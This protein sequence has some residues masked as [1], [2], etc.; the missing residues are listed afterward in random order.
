MPGCIWSRGTAPGPYCAGIA[1]WG[2][3]HVLIHTDITSVVNTG[4]LVDRDLFHPGDSFTVPG[5]P[6]R[7][8]L[9]PIAGP[10]LRAGDMVDYFR[11]VAPARGYAIHEAI[12][13]DNGPARAW[14]ASSAVHRRPGT[15]ATARSSW[16]RPS[17]SRRSD[18]FR[19]HLAAW[20]GA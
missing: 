15:D 5:E 14:P 8:L 10:W 18:S 11:E 2:E 19:C 7:T 9:V 1:Q 6:V 13:N 17:A 16:Y 3:S 4:F 20:V 12:L